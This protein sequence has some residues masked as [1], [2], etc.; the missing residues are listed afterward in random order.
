MA[1]ASRVPPV[2]AFNQ[3]INNHTNNVCPIVNNLVQ[4]RQRG[5]MSSNQKII[6]KRWS[7]SWTNDWHWSSLLNPMDS[8]TESHTIQQPLDNYAIHNYE[9]K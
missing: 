8:N 5:P 2:I 9:Q 3:T 4:F 7:Y 1:S 6:L